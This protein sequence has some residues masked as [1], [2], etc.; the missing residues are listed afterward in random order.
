MINGAVDIFRI[1]NIVMIL[2]SMACFVFGPWHFKLLSRDVRLLLMAVQALLMFAL[3]GTI[4]NLIADHA[5]NGIRT[6]VLTTALIWMIYAQH[7][8]GK[9]YDD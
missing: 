1:I 4:E 2:I 9:D 3:L 6:F 8:K 5:P 7:F